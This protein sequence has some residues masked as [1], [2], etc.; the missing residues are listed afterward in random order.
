M[1]HIVY[2]VIIVLFSSLLNAQV[3]INNTDP[4]A[5]L[6]ISASNIATPSN[7]D[8]LLI[9]RIEDFPSINPTTD[10]Q[11]M[12]VYLTTTSGSNP[13]GFYFW[14]NNAGPAAWIV[15]G[16]S[17]IDKINDLT[18]GK[19]DNDGTNDGS[20]VFL[21]KNSGANDDSSDNKN[22]GMGFEALQANTTGA[23]NLANGWRALYS[24]TTGG[25]NTA[26]GHMSLIFNTTGTAN[27]ANGSYSLYSNTTGY[28]NTASGYG[29]LNS[30]TDGIFN[31]AD[32]FNS[33]NLNTTGDYNTVSGTNSL[34][35]NTTGGFNTA[36]GSNSLY[37]NI[38]GGSNTAIGYRSGYTNTGSANIFLGYQ[39]GFNETGSNTLYIENSSA[40][41]D[42]ALIYGEFD[43]DI[44]RTNGE[45][46]IGNPTGTGYAFPVTD[47]TSGQL[48]S[49]D[50]S[51]Q[52]SFIDS[53]SFN[54]NDWTTVGPD[55]ERQSGDVYIG[56]TG[57][58]NNDLYI[59]DRII[60]WDNSSYYLDLD[61][62]SKVDEIYFDSGSASDPSIR[63]SDSDSGFYSPLFGTMAYSS[64]G[65]EAFRIN[66]VGDISIGTTSASNYKL[67]VETPFGL[68]KVYIGNKLSNNDVLKVDHNGDSGSG[69]QVNVNSSYTLNSRSGIS[70]TNSFVDVTTRI[71]RSFLNSRA[72][73]VENIIGGSKGLSIYGI[74]N[75]ITNSG[76]GIHRGTENRLLGTGT[77]TKY[78]SYNFISETAGGIHY[79]VYSY[80]PKAGSYAG[81]FLGNVAIGTNNADT[82]I[83]PSSRGTN[84]QIMQTDGTGGVSWVDTNTI[85]SDDQVID[86]FN[87]TGTTLNLSLENDGVALQTVDLSTL[88]DGTGTD[89]Q[90]ITGA[91]LTG[92]SL[93]IDIENGSSA[94][95]DLSSLQDAD[96]Y[97]TG[98]TPPN[99]IN[100]NIYTNGNVGIGTTTPDYKLSVSGAVNLNE[101]IASGVALR[102]N[103]TEALWYSG[104]YFSWGF[105]GSAN[106]FADNVGIST[107]APDTRLHLKH[108]NS[109][110]SGGFKLENSS[111]NYWRMY[112]SSGTSGDLRFYSSKIGGTTITGA[113]NGTSG[114]YTNVSDRRLKKDFMDLYF[115]WND[116]MDLKP[117]TYQF[118]SQIN[119]KK[120]IGLIAQDVLN[121]YPE[122][123]SY[124]KDEDLY[125]LDYSATGIV[126][127]KAIQELKLEVDKLIT[128]NQQLKDIIAKYENFENRLSLL[129]NK[130]NLPT[131][132]LVEI[133]K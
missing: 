132:E 111:A 100:D 80:V 125:H 39:S 26:N 61:D 73:G 65:I 20:S 110:T 11:G 38:I 97:E 51:G 37:S 103:G 2:L 118:K 50:G 79:G 10:Q 87:L 21:G 78:G 56:D 16:G 117:L 71:A 49:T 84:S 1:K 46:Q 15:V 31:T 119:N 4:K 18:D 8:G 55:I 67:L 24:N 74:Y 104:S 69:I 76:N 7:T 33:L 42:N 130:I 95:V 27:T 35:S 41:S 48:L 115:N 64:G 25:A 60:D 122:L 102:V 47:G 19:S 126:A 3:G 28:N 52:I 93:Q 45:F 81:Y 106:Y 120:H 53:S 57:A 6:D 54:D 75:F 105:G 63:F 109:G 91:T 72:Y 128:E 34:Y 114:A 23:N 36:S 66:S 99:S 92:T 131:S 29:S 121:I 101:D 88:Q 44:L 96:W 43:N 83:L 12:M 40:N 58:T 85:S 59:S 107:T 127:I 22:V 89:D 133:E 77:G 112:V 90:N 98:G 17:G 86:Q 62:I 113:F 30:N 68:N 5:S 94:L 116:F 9:P 32:G 124:T 108:T 82:Y 123:V 129:E 70:S 13:P 14:D